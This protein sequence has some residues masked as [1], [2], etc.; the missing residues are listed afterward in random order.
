[1]EQLY[2][3]K[4]LL[5]PMILLAHHVL[6]AVAASYLL[7][8]RFNPQRELEKHPTVEATE[9]EHQIQLAK[10]QEA[11]GDEAKSGEDNVRTEQLES[12]KSQERAK[13]VGTAE[14]WKRYR[15]AFDSVVTE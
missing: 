13:I 3:S 1:T 8:G 11:K 10:S 14:E 15:T 6:P 7:T 9:A 12:V 5:V 4:K 2:H